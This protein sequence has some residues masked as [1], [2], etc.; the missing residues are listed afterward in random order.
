[1]TRK[2]L[3]S[4]EALTEVAIEKAAADFLLENDVE[5]SL[6]IG[7]DWGKK[8]RLLHKPAQLSQLFDFE[9]VRHI[10][11]ERSKAYE[12]PNAQKLVDEGRI[13]LVN[14]SNK[15][16]EFWLK[17][18]L[19]EHKALRRV[20]IL[21]LGDVGSTMALAMCLYGRGVIGEIGIYDLSEERQQRWE[22]ELN[23]IGEPL[24][25]TLPKVKIIGEEE[26]FD[27]DLFAFTASVGVPPLTVKSGD[28]RAVQFEGN[29]KLVEKFVKMAMDRAFEGIFA[30]VSDPVDQLCRHAFES[31]LKYS[32][33]EGKSALRPDQIRGFGLGVM[34]GRA[35]YFAKAMG[36]KFEH[37]GRVYGP[38]GQ[39]L[40]VANDYRPEFYDAALSKQ[41][42]EQTIT[43]NLAMRELGH[44]PYVAP[45]VASGAIAI[46]KTLKGDWQY[47]CIGFNGF[48]YG[49]LNRQVEALIEIESLELPEQLRD[50]IMASV[51][52]QEAQWKSFW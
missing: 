51:E 32:E 4:L 20:N 28:V 15:A 27:C 14:R 48:Y 33:H 45:A 46:V 11:L 10:W 36:K 1:M 34:N 2:V 41:L 8:G 31:A 7:W 47:S 19:T 9:S 39:G 12:M 21:G 3:K 52:A 22:M 26:L 40:V 35:N 17:D 24:E 25:D 29:S 13:C 49:C 30:V 37:Y 44:K 38:H 43:A 5:A 50:S 23:Q 6:Y 42:T 16:Y 18:T